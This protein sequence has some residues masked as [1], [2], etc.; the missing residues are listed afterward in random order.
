MGKYLHLYNTIEDNINS[1]QTN[2]IDSPFIS[3]DLQSKSLIYDKMSNLSKNLLVGSLKFGLSFKNIIDIILEEYNQK[4][5][6]SIQFEYCKF[7]YEDKNCNIL[8]NWVPISY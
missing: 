3:Y 5:N 2:K 4:N 8:N 1:Y 6:S 7:V